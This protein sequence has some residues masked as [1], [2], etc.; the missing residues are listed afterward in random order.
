MAE[1]DTRIE[2]F[3]EP[4]TSWSDEPSE[5]ADEGQ[6]RYEERGSIGKG[7]MGTVFLVRDHALRREVAMKRLDPALASRPELVQAFV[8]EA[9]LSSQLEHPNVLSIHEL[10]VDTD[11]HPFFTM[12]VVRGNTLWAL[13]HDPER[14]PGSSERLGELIEVFLKV[15]DAVAYAHSRGVVHR[16]IKPDNIMVG[17]YGAVY[18]MDWGLAKVQRAAAPGLVDV[19]RPPGSPLTKVKE[20]AVGT[21]SY[22]P[23]EQARGEQHNVDT[24]SDIFALGAVLYHIVTG[25]MPYPGE[26]SADILKA[27]KSCT[28][29]PPEEVPGVFVQKKIARVIQRAMAM[30]PADRFQ[31]VAELKA[32]VQRFLHGGLH[33]PRQH[34][35][36]G[37]CIVQEGTVGEEAYIITRGTCEVYKTVGGQRKVVR[38]LGIGDVFGELGVISASPRSAS[39]E[40]LERVTTLVLTR[41]VLDEGFAAGSWEGLIVK[42]LVERFRE[43]DS[44]MTTAERDSLHGRD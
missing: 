42:S 34:F 5:R 9:Q 43:L 15:C 2:P 8:E 35:S 37:D 28:F 29:I 26:T 38:Q 14:P 19:P 33:L 4:S 44:R 21:P 16:D 10:G 40:A 25:K 41:E 6:S 24:R 31:S 20:G 30:D 1:R 39:V 27:A 18:L 11:G 17:P 23:P 36:K 22:M 13:L 12:R 32:Q 7:G 3:E